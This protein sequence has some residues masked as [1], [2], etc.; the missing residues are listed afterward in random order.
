MRAIENRGCN[1]RGEEADNNQNCAAY[2][3]LILRKAIRKQDLIEQA[4]KGIEAA[5]E[6]AKG[7]EYDVEGW[8]A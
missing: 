7:E 8:R 4:G 3:G 2:P 6:Y 5:G 1:R